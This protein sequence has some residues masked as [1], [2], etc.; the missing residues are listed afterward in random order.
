MIWMILGVMLFCAALVAVG[1]IYRVEKRISMRSAATVLA[2]MGIAVGVYT[3]TGNPGAQST[4]PGAMPS[5]DEMVTIWS[6]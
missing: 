5:V 2:V 4:H 3:F 1:P 6:A